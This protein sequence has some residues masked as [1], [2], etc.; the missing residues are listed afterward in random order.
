MSGSQ[1]DPME[2]LSLNIKLLNWKCVSPHQRSNHEFLKISNWHSAII[3][4]LSCISAFE[5][6]FLIQT[7]EFLALCVATISR[8]HFNFKLLSCSVE[9]IFPTSQVFLSCLAYF[10]LWL[11]YCNLFSMYHAP[12][13]GVKQ[14]V[15]YVVW[16]LNVSST[17]ETK[18]TI[19]SMKFVRH[20][21]NYLLGHSPRK[22]KTY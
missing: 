15:H 19:S 20:L 4:H 17:K 22:V 16:L 11:L 9:I 2:L 3:N 12:G 1:G 13:F 6:P 5:M 8:V 10:L 18:G 14:H 7:I 21:S